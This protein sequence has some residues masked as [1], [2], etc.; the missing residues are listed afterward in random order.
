[1]KKATFLKK[2]EKQ[3]VNK[4]SCAYKL[5]SN[6]NSNIIRTCWTSGRG[7][8]TTNMDYT[9]QVIDLLTQMNVPFVTGNDSPR[10]GKT[11]NFVNLY[12]LTFK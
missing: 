8:F 9:A 6:V 7:R 10:G 2:L 5:L 1:M 4:N 3:E 11:G 12:T